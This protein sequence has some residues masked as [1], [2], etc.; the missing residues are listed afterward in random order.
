[1]LSLMSRDMPEQVIIIRLR[2]LQQLPLLHATM[3]AQPV[4]SRDIA[5]SILLC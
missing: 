4:P 2:A 3:L 5:V 1:M